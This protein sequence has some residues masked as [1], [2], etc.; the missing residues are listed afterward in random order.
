MKTM[1]E[2]LTVYSKL[3]SDI[4]FKTMEQNPLYAD[5]KP[6]YHTISIVHI[7]RLSS[8]IICDFMSLLIHKTSNYLHLLLINGDVGI[9]PTLLFMQTPNLPLEKADQKWTTGEQQVRKPDGQKTCLFILYKHWNEQSWIRGKKQIF[10]NPSPKSF[11]FCTFIP[12]QHKMLLFDFQLFML[13][14]CWPFCLLAAVYN[15]ADCYSVCTYVW[16][17]PV[18]TAFVLFILPLA[19]WTGLSSTLNLGFLFS[20]V[21]ILG[22]VYDKI[23]DIFEYI[24]V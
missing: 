2:K 8:H 15:W 16:T 19:Q 21:Q 12:S 23:F 9:C 22:I 5:D 4:F 20:C 14:P 11:N 6:V 1:K 13:L 7:M 10:L 24:K 17:A 18:I 3:F